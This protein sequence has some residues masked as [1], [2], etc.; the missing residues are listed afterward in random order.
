MS[1]GVVFDQVAKLENHLCVQVC[2]SYF[3]GLLSR[4]CIHVFFVPFVPFQF[5]AC[6]LET[7]AIGCVFTNTPS[8]PSIPSIPPA[9]AAFEGISALR[10]SNS[11]ERAA[12]NAFSFLFFTA[13]LHLSICFS[14]FL[15]FFDFCCFLSCSIPLS[16]LLSPFSHCEI[17]FSNISLPAFSG[18]MACR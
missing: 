3:T 13:N 17:V 18:A 7:I 10:H 1:A 9:P 12:C 2:G 15:S 6:V 8:D 11:T 16:L 14:F 5:C 4:T